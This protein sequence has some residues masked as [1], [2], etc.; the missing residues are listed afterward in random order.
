MSALHIV[1][2]DILICS[3]NIRYLP[4]SE[5]MSPEFLDALKLSHVSTRISDGLYEIFG[6]L[7]VIICYSQ[8]SYI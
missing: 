5:S 8:V 3:L 2:S 7:Y 1:I 4:T 6:S